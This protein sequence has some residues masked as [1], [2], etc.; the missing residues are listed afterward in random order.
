[1]YKCVAE[2]EEKRAFAT[3][4]KGNI[5]LVEANGN[6]LDILTRRNELEAL[7]RTQV[8]DEKKLKD[9]KPVA[10][11]V[12][13][14]I[15]GLFMS[16]AGIY[17]FLHRDLGNIVLIIVGI[18]FSVIMSSALGS[19]LGDRRKVKEALKIIREQIKQKNRD[20]GKLEA[21]SGFQEILSLDECK[22]IRDELPALIYSPNESTAVYRLS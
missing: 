5:S 22:A 10:Y 21:E 19:E 13:G 16:G 11:G 15:F 6:I 1:M 14:T 9:K 7:E 2:F 3:D 17:G 8:A 20:I 18:I 4:D 12:V